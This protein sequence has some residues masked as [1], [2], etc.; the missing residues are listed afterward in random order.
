MPHIEPV[1][2]G[3]MPPTL[4]EAIER[5][6]SS[7]MLG[8]SAPVQVW[9]HRPHAALAWLDTIDQ[10]H[11]HGLLAARLRELVR[12]RIAAITACKACQLARKSD[13]VSDQDIACLASDNPRFSPAEQAALRYAELFAGDY[14]AIDG[15]LFDQL[16]QCFTIAEIVELNMFCALMLAGGR[17]TFVQNSIPQE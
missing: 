16:K 13:D 7:R 1:A 4:R 2:M 9:A 5:G 3:D 15:A 10:F 8:S 17:M 12:L 11:S 14:M 6:L